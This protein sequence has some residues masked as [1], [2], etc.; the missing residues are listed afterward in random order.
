MRH[1][2]CIALHSRNDTICHDLI[3]LSLVLSVDNHLVIATK[4][5]DN[6]VNILWHQLNYA[7]K[8]NRHIFEVYN[9]LRNLK[10]VSDW[11]N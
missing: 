9:D 7:I 1:D 4:G 10:K 8:Y 11:K 3:E 2:H 5:K 6:F